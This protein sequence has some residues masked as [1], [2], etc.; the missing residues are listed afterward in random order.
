MKTC[1]ITFILSSHSGASRV[2]DGCYSHPPVGRWL[3]EWP[4]HDKEL[5]V[6][7][8]SVNTCA[9]LLLWITLLFEGRQKRGR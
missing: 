6:D 1:S 8:V 7:T 5:I 3:F 4:T 9:K 2:V